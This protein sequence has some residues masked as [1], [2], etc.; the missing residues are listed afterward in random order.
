MSLFVIRS[1][2]WLDLSRTLFGPSGRPTEWRRSCADGDID[3]VVDGEWVEPDI[4]F[5][6]EP[7]P[8]LVEVIVEF[9]ESAGDYAYWPQEI[10]DVFVVGF[11]FAVVLVV[12]HHQFGI[13]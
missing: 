12:A 11:G 13:R 4:G 1:L 2:D 7:V 10:G 8:N 6:G 5:N 9:V 3:V